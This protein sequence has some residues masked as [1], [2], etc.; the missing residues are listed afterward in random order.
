MVIYICR[1]KV[2][3]IM[4]RQ[5]SAELNK[6]SA[7]SLKAC[8]DFHRLSLN[9]GTSDGGGRKGGGVRIPQYRTW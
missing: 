2:D 1:E 7:V 5:S 4:H 8:V 3:F 9:S 6:G